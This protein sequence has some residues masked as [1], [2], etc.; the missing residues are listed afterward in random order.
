MLNT[1][2]Q[3][4]KEYKQH[5]FKSDESGAMA[6]VLAIALIPILLMIGMAVEWRQASNTRA[7]LQNLLDIAVLNTIIELNE[8]GDFSKVGDQFSAIAKDAIPFETQ[9]SIVETTRGVSGT[10]SV[11]VPATFTSI[12][13][14]T[15]FNIK[16]TAL[17]GVHVTN[18]ALPC[19]TT[20]DQ[21]ENASLG[22]NSG[23]QINAPECEVHVHSQADPAASFTSGAMLDTAGVCIAGPDVSN[24]SALAAGT[25]FRLNCDVGPDPLAGV[26]PEPLFSSCNGH[27]NIISGPTTLQ[28]G[29]YCGGLIFNGA[30]DVEFAPGLYIIRNGGWIVNGGSWRGDGVTFYFE[31]SST[32]LF[33][34]DVNIKL[35]APDN[36]D[37]ADILFTEAPNLPESNF[38]LND[39]DAFDISGVIYLPSRNMTINSN[40]NAR[41]FDLVLVVNNFTINNAQWDLTGDLAARFGGVETEIALIQ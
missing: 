28:P 41:A 8:S 29:V 34:S 39:T 19:I 3:A 9:H 32:L 30:P 24:N 27:P 40:G 22:V 31:D 7:H 18:R 37:Y 17:A 26:I 20:L 21:S 5:S 38:I 33:N 14:Q 35:S 10:A 36:G 4:R 23:A 25:D 1:R 2:P 13:G 15:G 6:I 12:T 16:V 11:F